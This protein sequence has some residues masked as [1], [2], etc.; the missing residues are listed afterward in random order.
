M[1]II[2]L[3]LAALIGLAGCYSNDNGALSTPECLSRI[4]T[5]VAPEVCERALPALDTEDSTRNG[6][7][8]AQARG[9]GHGVSFII[10][11]NAVYTLR[12]KA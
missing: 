10:V 12:S 6:Y 1:R 8:D 5:N 11:N 3:A 4:G 7:W 9:N 2:G